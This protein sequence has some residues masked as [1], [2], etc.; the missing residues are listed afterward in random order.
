MVFLLCLKDLLLFDEDFIMIQL[1]LDSSIS[2]VKTNNIIQHIY[3]VYETFHK[4][5]VVCSKS[6]L[7][8]VS[9]TIILSPTLRLGFSLITYNSGNCLF[10]LS[11]EG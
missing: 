7:D 2:T 8:F 10:L 6:N 4:S 9:W 1:I 11:V 3:I 5:R